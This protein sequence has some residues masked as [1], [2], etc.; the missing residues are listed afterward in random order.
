MDRVRDVEEKTKWFTID[1]SGEIDP[2]AYAGADIVIHTAGVYGRRGESIEEIT[3]ANTT[4]PMKILKDAVY[5]G[6]KKFI[7]IDSALPPQTNPYTSSKAQFAQGGK[8]VAESGEIQFIN[9]RLEHIYGPGDD[10]I[11]FPCHVMNACRRNVPELKLTEGTQKRDFIFVGDAVEAVLLLAKNDIQD[12]RGYAE[13]PLGSGVPTT[14]RHFV[15][16]VHQIAH[17]ST[18][19]LFGAIPAK[20]ND[21]MYSCADISVL[22]KLGWKPAIRLRD[23]L[24]CTI[25]TGDSL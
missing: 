24:E 17:S 18:H 21:V 5:H 23:G 8:H 3:N 25:Q 12:T 1:P 20:P 7:H 9:I 6:V 15:E 2:R 11:K 14:I 22:E 16:L 19:L 10:E 4:I 13:I